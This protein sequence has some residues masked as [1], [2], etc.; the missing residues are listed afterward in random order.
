MGLIPRG[1]ILSLQSETSVQEPPYHKFLSLLVDTRE[2]MSGGD[3]SAK[4]FPATEKSLENSVQ[5][6]LLGGVI[7]HGGQYNKMFPHVKAGSWRGLP[8]RVRWG[9]FLL[10]LSLKS[11]SFLLIV[12]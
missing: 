8:L 3:G 4:L 2:V 9:P 1:P 5:T 7:L 12:F 11:I 10:K 6:W